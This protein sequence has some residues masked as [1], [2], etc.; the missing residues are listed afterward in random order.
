M[1]DGLEGPGVTAVG[2][3]SSLYAAT[4]G[5]ISIHDL[6]T[7]APERTLPGARG[8]INSMQIS[9]DGSTMLVTANDDTVS[10]IDLASGIRLG[11]AIPA[12]APRIIQGFLRPD[13]REAVVN[14]EPGIQRWDLDPQHQ[15]VPRPPAGSPGENSPQRNGLPIWAFSSAPLPPAR[16]LVPDRIPEYR[17]NT[18]LRPTESHVVFMVDRKARICPASLAGSF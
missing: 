18:A 10:L 17:G 11:D 9:G 16:A 7:L 1:I 3:D 8:E 13:A 12:Y 15:I 14:I 4:D 2:P 6:E 5:R